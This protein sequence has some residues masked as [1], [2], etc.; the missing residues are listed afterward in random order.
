MRG[1][2]LLRTR[3]LAF[4]LA[5]QVEILEL[6]IAKLE[7]LVRLKDAK[8]GKLQGALVEKRQYGPEP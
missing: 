1:L 2:W 8:I 6:K 3:C 4:T 7:Q 5:L